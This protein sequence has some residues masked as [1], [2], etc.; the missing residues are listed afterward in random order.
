[1]PLLVDTV[2]LKVE[3]DF[4]DSRD[5]AC[6]YYSYDS[7]KWLRLGSEL[8]MIYQLRHFTGYR[9]ALFSYAT[10]KIGGYVDFDFMRY[11]PRG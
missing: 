10:E 4:T 11:E 3:F 9:A 2:H 5:I 8:K 1:V 6:F 7:I